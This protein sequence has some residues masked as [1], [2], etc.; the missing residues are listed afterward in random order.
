MKTDKKP[1][2]VD[3]IFSGSFVFK[4]MKENAEHLKKEY[5]ELK[6]KQFEYELAVYCVGVVSGLAIGLITVIIS[7]NVIR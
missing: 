5:A 2:Q 6:R 3:D 4:L 1:L 7:V